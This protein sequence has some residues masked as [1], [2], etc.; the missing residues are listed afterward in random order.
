[1]ASLLERDRSTVGTAVGLAVCLVAVLGS[2]FLGWE[3]G[4]GQF[5]PAVIGVAAVVAAGVLAYRRFCR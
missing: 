4:S 1:M 5:V 2:Q 3:W